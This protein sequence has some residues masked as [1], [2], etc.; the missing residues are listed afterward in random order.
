MIR[1]D[2]LQL[3]RLIRQVHA[4]ANA[5]LSR[6]RYV[7]ELTRLRL[8]ESFTLPIIIAR[9]LAIVGYGLSVFLES[10]LRISC[11]EIHTFPTPS[12]V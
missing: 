3:H 12:S 4:S 5:I 9:I 7:I 1:A 2:D 11:P 6:I 10:C 8:F